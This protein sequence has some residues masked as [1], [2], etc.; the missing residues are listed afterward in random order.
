MSSAA[1]AR[2]SNT[3]VLL[4][5]AA[6]A[7]GPSLR[8][9]DDISAPAALYR[10]TLPAVAWVHA[11]DQGKGTGWV[12]DRSRRWLV[13]NYHVVGETKTVEVFFPVTG[14]SDRAAYLEKRPQLEKDGYVVRGKVLRRNPDIDLALIELAS[15]PPGVGELRLADASAQPGDR[16]Y[17]IG[18]RYDCDPLW[19]HTGGTVRLR[20]VWKEGYFNGGKQLAKGV[21]VVL[22]Q[23]QICEGDSGAPGR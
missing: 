5:A 21:Q 7:G 20:L 8:V 22:T 1:S 16:I 4:L 11:P 15:L 13:T 14:M 10:R 12:I 23:A 18:N 2:G 3:V 6:L 17:L 19:V 9:G